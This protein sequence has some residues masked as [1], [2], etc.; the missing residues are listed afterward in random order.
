MNFAV[1]LGYLKNFDN[2]LI[3]AWSSG[4]GMAGVGGSAI[5]LG[6]VAAGLD[7]KQTF[8]ARIPWL[9]LYLLALHCLIRAP[10]TPHS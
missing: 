9:V 7:F 6:Y 8:L 2:M 1:V 4:T 10:A 3:N 5:Y